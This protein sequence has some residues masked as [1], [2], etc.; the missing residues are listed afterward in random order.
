MTAP[1]TRSQ[2]DPLGDNLHQLNRQ[3]AAL[4]EQI[5]RALGVDLHCW[6]LWVKSGGKWDFRFKA[7]HERL[8][9]AASVFCGDANPVSTRHGDLEAAHLS[10]DF[11]DSQ[12]RLMQAGLPLLTTDVNKLISD[13]RDLYELSVIEEKRLGLVLDYLSKRQYPG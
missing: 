3:D 13:C 12:T 4:T 9:D 1:I 11:H 8:K 6:D 10:I 2:F 7:G 5:Q